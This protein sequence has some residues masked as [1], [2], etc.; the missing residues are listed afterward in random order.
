[1]RSRTCSGPRPGRRREPDRRRGAGAENRVHRQHHD[2]LLRDAARKDRGGRH[3]RA[4][5]ARGRTVRRG[6]AAPPSNVDAR[7]KLAELVRR[8]WQ[9]SRELTVVFADPS[10]HPQAPGGLWTACRRHAARPAIRVTEPLS[11]IEFMNLVSHC[12]HRHHRL[13]RRA[14]RD[15]LPGRPVRDAAREHR[16]AD[17]HHRGHEPAAEARRAGRG[18]WRSARGRAGRG[19][20]DLRCGTGTRRSARRRA[21]ARGCSREAAARR[22]RAANCGESRGRA[23]RLQHTRQTSRGRAV[24][25][26]LQGA[27]AQATFQCDRSRRESRPP[28]L[29]NGLRQKIRGYA[30]RPLHC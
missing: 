5:A 4:P 9:L 15:H 3:A 20:K 26:Y 6:D 24:R 13:R 29:G 25:A 27:A 23:R 16:A 8:W 22:H 14:G 21:C 18:G 2:R 30:I 19:A 10:A 1:M 28:E 7:D 17:H 12:D 11:Y